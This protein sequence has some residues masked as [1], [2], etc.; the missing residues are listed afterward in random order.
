[1]ANWI[2]EHLAWIQRL[3]GF[4]IDAFAENQLAED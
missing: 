3:V 4:L 2:L 1:V